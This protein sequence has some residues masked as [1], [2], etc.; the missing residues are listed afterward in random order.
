MTLFDYYLQYMTQVWEGKRPAPEGIT[1]LRGRWHDLTIPGLGTVP[2]LATLHP[3]YL[4]RTPIAKRDA[5][6]D[7]LLL[8]RTL[9]GT[10][11]KG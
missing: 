8:R 10:S 7:L 3:A 9:D 1:R 5:W 2:A 4:L 11:T 6:S